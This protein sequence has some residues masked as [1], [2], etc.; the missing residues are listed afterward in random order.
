[1]QEVRNCAGK[2]VCCVDEETHS[3]IIVIR[4]MKTVITFNSDGTFEI[5]NNKC[6]Q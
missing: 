5:I 6:T 4:N 1:M 2:K 3:V